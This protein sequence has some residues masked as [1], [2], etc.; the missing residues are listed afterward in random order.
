[1]AKKPVAVLGAGAWGTAVSLLLA[2]NGNPV[3]LWAHEESVVRD[4]IQNR[5]NSHYL[6]DVIIPSL[7]T[8]STSLRDTLKDVDYIFEAIPVSFL[9]TTLQ[10]GAPYVTNKQTWIILSKGI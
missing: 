1:M 10:A 8:P 4:I 3:Q 9:R 5:F 6:P 2:E 7:I